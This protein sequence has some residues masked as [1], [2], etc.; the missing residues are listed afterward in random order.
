MLKGVHLDVVEVGEELKRAEENEFSS[1]CA[2][3]G[4]PPLEEKKIFR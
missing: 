3:R 2:H 4:S 1:G